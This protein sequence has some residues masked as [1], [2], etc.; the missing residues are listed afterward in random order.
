MVLAANGWW[1]WTI[2]AL[3][4]WI[5]IAFWP[6]RVA[7]RKGHSFFG[8]FIF[9]LI[10]FPAAL[11]V[12]YVVSDKIRRRK[13][14]LRNRPPR[15]GGPREQTPL[16]PRG[17]DG[18]D[19]AS[20]SQDRRPCVPRRRGHRDRS[21]DRCRDATGRRS[22]EENPQRVLGVALRQ[23]RGHEHAAP[24]RSAKAVETLS[25]PT[26]RRHELAPPRAPRAHRGGRRVHS[27][28]AARSPRG[29][30][31]RRRGRGFLVGGDT[32]D[33]DACPGSYSRR[34]TASR[35]SIPATTSTA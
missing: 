13:W 9:S 10:F 30:E 6:A 29:G 18:R 12:A 14:L 22:T 34:L 26:K 25:G 35:I 33:V 32:C 11:I 28:R 7:A 2:L 15:T 19:G 4:I 24:A 27:P 21:W 23:R 8:Y 20:S 5:A 31:D 17:R 3:A 16:L 1:L